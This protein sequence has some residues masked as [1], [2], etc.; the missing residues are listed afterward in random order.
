MSVDRAAQADGKYGAPGP[1][2]GARHPGAQGRLPYLILRVTHSNVSCSRSFAAKSPSAGNAS[3]G[4]KCWQGVGE[5]ARY[6]QIKSLSLRLGTSPV[7]CCL[8]NSR[9]TWKGESATSQKDLPPAGGAE[10]LRGP[11]CFFLSPFSSC[12]PSAFSASSALKAS[13]EMLT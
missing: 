8:L 11:S 1:P 6:F 9:D 13:F 7:P 12:R 10:V 2:R 3:L 5:P 4:R